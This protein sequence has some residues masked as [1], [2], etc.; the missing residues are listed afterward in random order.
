MILRLDTCGNICCMRSTSASLAR[1]LF[2]DEAPRCEVEGL[3]L[4]KK[5]YRIARPPRARI[6]RSC[7]RFIV[8]SDEDMLYG[9]VGKRKGGRDESGGC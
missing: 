9:G 3:L 7:G 4:L 5:K 2:A 6:R 8:W 1:T